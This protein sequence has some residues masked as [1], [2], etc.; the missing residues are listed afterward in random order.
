M[1]QETKKENIACRR[2]RRKALLTAAPFFAVLLAVGVLAWCLPLRPSVSETEKRRLTEF[3]AF[4]FR[5]LMDGSF[6]H[7]VDLWFSDTFPLR[8]SWIAAADEVKS[9]HGFGSVELYSAP[10]ANA[11][12][13]GDESVPEEE[14][15]PRPLP[16][17]TESGVGQPPAEEPAGSAP[18]EEPADEGWKGLSLADEDF[19]NGSSLI[20]IGSSAYWL[21]AYNE[22]A[23]A[24]F[25]SAIRSAAEILDGKAGFYVMTVPNNISVLYSRADRDFMGVAPEEDLLE[26][27]AEASGGKVKTVDVFGALSAH[28]GE[29]ICFRSDHH[30]TSLGA[31]YAYAAWCEAA[32]KEAA[33]LDS[34]TEGHWDGYL[35]T[36]YDS[37]KSKAMREDPDTVYY[38]T[39]PGDVHLYITDSRSDPVGP[40]YPLFRD[41]TNAPKGSLFLTFLN[42][43]HALCTLVNN[44]IEDDSSI[45]IYK[46]SMGNQL[47]YFFTRHYHTVYVLDSRKYGGGSITESLRLY[48]PDDVVYCFNT[49]YVWSVG[50]SGVIEKFSK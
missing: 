19:H 24:R 50:G 37:T 6:F 4:S 49:N 31:Y 7:G 33:P 12:L 40:E 43:D 17:E 36:A 26:K 5:A 1:D 29:Y 48:D 16:A 30:W 18:E 25:V 34:F 15:A 28:C 27:L 45:L 21:P 47:A 3:P 10:G 32:G 35:G 39:P 22:S 41:M 23:N 11:D 46:N 44:S 38:Y 9:L 8:D 13:G 2:A 14:P 42:G 20:R